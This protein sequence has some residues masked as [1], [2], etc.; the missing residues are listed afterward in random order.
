MAL[1]LVHVPSHTNTFISPLSSA[2]MPFLRIVVRAGPSVTCPMSNFLHISE[3]KIPQILKI[4][5]KNEKTE[6]VLFFS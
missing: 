1:S 6:M 4:E 5:V 2:V 3:R